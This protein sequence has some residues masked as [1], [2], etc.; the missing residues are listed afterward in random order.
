MSVN[1][2]ISHT[3]A[4]N[5]LQFNASPELSIG[6]RHFQKS[7]KQPKHPVVL[8]SRQLVNPDFLL[9]QDYLNLIRDLS[10]KKF[11]LLPTLTRIDLPDSNLELQFELHHE[12]PDIVAITNGLIPV[13]GESH[14]KLYRRLDREKLVSGM[15][16]NAAQ[17]LLQY[18]LG[19]T[20]PNYGVRTK[21]PTEVYVSGAR[22]YYRH[23]SDPTNLLD[24][25]D[26]RQ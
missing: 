26:N 4:I 16:I 15:A 22:L 9:D 20:L 19:D 3:K 7:I 13:D 21:A 17:T 14:S 23:P 25:R 12:D 18:R 8:Y 24:H 10:S 2:E 6:I 11:T 1:P 5:R